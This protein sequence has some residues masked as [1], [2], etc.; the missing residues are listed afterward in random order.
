MVEQLLTAGSREVIEG[1]TA[2]PS[3][4]EEGELGWKLA[5][6]VLEQ[7]SVVVDVVR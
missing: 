4:G 2:R 7:S 1:E 5:F 3:I 6:G